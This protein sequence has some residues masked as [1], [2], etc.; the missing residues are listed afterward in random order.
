[1]KNLFKFIGVAVI[2]LA[3]V[4]VQPCFGS[5]T[6]ES[7]LTT[8]S[9]DSSTASITSW[10]TN[11]LSTNAITWTYTNGTA[12]TT[13]TL[14]PGLLTGKARAIVNQEHMVL[15]LQGWLVNTSSATIGV[16]LV[17]ACTG[18]SGPVVNG[19]TVSGINTNVFNNLNAASID[20]ESTGHWFT[21]TCPAGTNWIN[22]QQNL[23]TDALLTA[24]N[25]PNADFVGVYQITNNFTSGNSLVNPNGVLFLNKKLIPTPL[26]GQ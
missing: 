4:A 11:G 14:Y 7:F 1:M 25:L 15:N 24:G 2:G 13:N 9:I 16:Q 26:I 6:L 21:F 18:G 17:T 23:V 10:P 19:S 22:L 5:G 3:T 20:F 12:I 8:N